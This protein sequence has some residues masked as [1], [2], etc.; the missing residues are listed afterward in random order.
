MTKLTEIK[1][2]LE[3]YKKIPKRFSSH[4]TIG[5]SDYLVTHLEK[6]IEMAE[7]YGEK[8]EWI[9]FKEFGTHP[10]TKERLPVTSRFDSDN[11]GQKAR[12]FLKQLRV[13]EGDENE[14]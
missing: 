5:E 9:D 12:D 10:K 8:H 3:R 2:H 11:N 7:Y 13:D 14:D 1:V 4:L 6:A